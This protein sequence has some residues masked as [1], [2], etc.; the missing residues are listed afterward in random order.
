MDTSFTEENYLKA[1]YH[2]SRE[3]DELINTN[4][5]ALVMNTRPASVTDMIKKLNGKNLLKYLPYQ[6][7]CLTGNGESIALE[8]IRKHRLW[9]FFLVEKLN[10]GWEEVHELAEQLEHVQSAKLIDKL[11]AFLGFP[12]YDPH[13]DPIPDQN[14]LIGACLAKPLNTFLSGEKGLIFSVTEYS[15]SFLKY[16]EK[17]ELTIGAL[18]MVEELIEFDGSIIISKENGQ[19]I[20]ISKI[21]ANNILISY[22]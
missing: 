3:D 19:Q 16:L 21:A 18:I 14:G 11:D 6:G 15:A 12:K 1:I 9:E 7:V 5:I 17:M 8:I 22:E 10:F 13:G 20:N 2:L 4:R